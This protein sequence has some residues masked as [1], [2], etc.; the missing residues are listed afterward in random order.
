VE[1]I[2]TVNIIAVVNKVAMVTV[3]SVATLVISVNILITCYHSDHRN[4]G[5]KGRHGNISKEF[6]QECA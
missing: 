4:T 5:N 3:K 6:S 2:N 1:W